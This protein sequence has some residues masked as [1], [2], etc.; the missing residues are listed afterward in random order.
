MNNKHCS[1]CMH[2]QITRLT[3]LKA[4]NDHSASL[5]ILSE[6]WCWTTGA[7]VKLKATWAIS[8][9]PKHHQYN[10]LEHESQSRRMLGSQWAPCWGRDE[11]EAER[12]PD[13]MHTCHTHAH[14][15]TGEVMERPC[16]TTGHSE[17]GAWAT[18]ESCRHQED[19]CVG[20]VNVRQ[21][22]HVLW[23]SSL[24]DSQNNV[25]FLSLVIKILY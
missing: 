20:R 11:A 1:S 8:Y 2:I 7:K 22:A 14:R 19:E 18:T 6:N 25:T 5:D 3:H 4:S 17:I 15:H 13:A 12:T 21:E 23:C 9:R 10:K 24:V 16:Y